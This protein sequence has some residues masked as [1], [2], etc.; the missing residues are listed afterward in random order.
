MRKDGSLT[1]LLKWRVDK[2]ID[3]R[4][5]QLKAGWKDLIFVPSGGKGSDEIISEAEAI[6]NY[7]IKKWIDEKNI[8]IEDKAK[9]T[10]ENIKFSN[11]LINN[12]NANIAFS[13][14][15]YHILRAGLLATEQWLYFEWMWSKTK[16]YFWINAFI[17]E[18]IWTLYTERKKHRKIIFWIVLLIIFMI[19]V[20]YFAN[21]F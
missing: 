12:K 18:F 19:T 17:R 8:L 2:A 7:L 21:N 9:N 6:K 10:Y 15:K 14:T 4:N 13:T 1:N 20:T 16:R 11:K 3:F 5:K